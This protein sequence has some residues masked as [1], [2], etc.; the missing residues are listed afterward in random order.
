M[1]SDTK[2][3]RVA[4]VAS[5]RSCQEGPI[6]PSVRW[7][8]VDAESLAVG[9]GHPLGQAKEQTS[10]L[11]PRGS[12]HSQSRLKPPMHPGA[13]QDAP[14]WYADVPAAVAASHQLS[15]FWGLEA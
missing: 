3:G 1:G 7:P 12:F 6:L 15:S 8:H 2:S 13:R 4:T 11:G 14:S 5:D 9:L 10:F